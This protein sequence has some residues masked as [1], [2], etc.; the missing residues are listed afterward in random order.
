MMGVSM[1]FING[2]MCDDDD[3]ECDSKQCDQC[4]LVHANACSVI[5]EKD[6]EFG[7]IQLMEP[8]VCERVL[9]PSECI[10]GNDICHLTEQQRDEFKAVLDKYADCFSE[11]PGYCNDV[12]HEIIV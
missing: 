6:E 1:C 8:P 10:D 12:E 2:E 9:L 11:I 7:R 5:Y 3:D 4:E